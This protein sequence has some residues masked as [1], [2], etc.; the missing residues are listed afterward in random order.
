MDA[1]HKSTDFELG[2]IH[3]FF[4]IFRYCYY[5][6]KKSKKKQKNMF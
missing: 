4:A 3:N 5:K 2:L 6:A 1:Y